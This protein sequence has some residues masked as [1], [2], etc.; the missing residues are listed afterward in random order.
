MVSLTSHI[1]AHRPGVHEKRDVHGF[2]N[3][4]HFLLFPNPDGVT[5]E[6]PLGLGTEFRI[7]FL[8]QRPNG[9]YLLVEIENPQAS[10]FTKGGNFSAA[11]NHALRQVEDWQEWIEA[12]LPNSGTVLPRH[13][14]SRSVGSHRARP[15][16]G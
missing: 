10:L 8:I 14:G 15:P 2:I 5:S 12:N 4:H 1:V 7:D 3:S 16:A 13:E 9:S 6:V 11:V